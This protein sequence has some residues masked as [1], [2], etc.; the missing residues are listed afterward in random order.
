MHYQR[1]VWFAA[2]AALTAACGHVGVVNTPG[3]P[4]SEVSA[5]PPSPP[6]LQGDTHLANA[7]DFYVKT[8]TESAY[9]FTTPSGKWNCAIVPHS[10]AGCQS[11]AGPS[12]GITGAPATVQNGDGQDVAPNAVQI[13]DDGGAAFVRVDS[14]GFALASGKPPKLDFAVTLAAAGFRCNVQE[15]GVSCLNEA[16]RQG[17]TFS[18]ESLVPQYTPV[19]G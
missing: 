9:Y 5:P 13:G 7:F 12:L 6:A 17:F 16:T 8:D 19:P 15:S 14:P 2:A 18:P 1:I 10:A 3:G 11:A 4:Q